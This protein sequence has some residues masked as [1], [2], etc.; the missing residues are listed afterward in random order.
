MLY[1]RYITY[2]TSS[3]PARRSGASGRTAAASPA[4][5]SVPPR[6]I[7]MCGEQYMNK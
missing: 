1:Y 5:I 6:L 3:L 7:L 4:A 2:F